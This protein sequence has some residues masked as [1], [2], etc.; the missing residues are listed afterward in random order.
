M[1]IFGFPGNPDGANNL[2]LLD[3][4]RAVE[5]VRD[6]IA[7]FGGD[8][9]RITLFGQSA[10]S[11]SVDYYSF[12]WT[13]DPIAKGFI[14]QSGTV[15]G[16]PGQTKEA[17]TP[18][19]LAAAR[20]VGCNPANSMTNSPAITA[21]M[22]TAPA[23]AILAASNMVASNP[24][25]PAT[26]FGAM[27]ATFGPVI[28][29]T[30]VF[31]DYTT[32]TPIKAGVLLGNNDNEPGFAAVFMPTMV[33]AANTQQELAVFNCPSAQRALLS[34]NQ[35]NPTWRYRWFGVFPNTALSFNPPSG[36]YHVS[37]VSCRHK[38]PGMSVSCVTD[39]PF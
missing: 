38:R 24:A 35:G 23:D 31:A 21:C 36:A 19:W 12:A 1:G 8:P 4:R 2:G 3:Q 33:A 14:M 30:V 5:W 20:I 13:Q 11:A 32:R 15:L 7:N 22:Q 17:T 10:G 16:I 39:R 9:E 29:N 6:N 28:D 26:G 18:I 37:E 27:G 25:N 34:I